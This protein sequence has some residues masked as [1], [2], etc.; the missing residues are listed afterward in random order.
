MNQL[1]QHEDLHIKKK[2]Y[3][4]TIVGS[5]VFM[6]IVML[7]CLVFIQNDKLLKQNET[8]ILIQAENQELKQQLEQLKKDI[9]NLQKQNAVLINKKSGKSAVIP[10]TAYL[11]FDDG[12]STNT[13]K[14]LDVLAEHNVKATFFI[15]GRDNQYYRMLYQRMINEGHVIAPHTYSHRYSEIY[16]SFES[17]VEDQTKLVN[18]ILDLGVQNPYIMR[19]PGGSGNTVAAQFGGAQLMDQI[20]KHYVEL[21]YK[22]FDWNVDSMDSSADLL[23]AEQIA[24]NV[25]VASKKLSDPIILMHDSPAKKTTPYALSQIITQLKQAGYKFDVLSVNVKPVVQKSIS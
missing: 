2:Y 18:L 15:V 13:E 25:I 16:S 8:I 6:A 4:I 19:F 7:F 17:F 21:G 1:K 5:F 3:K 10:Q 11:T 22:Y 24:N 12:P 14:I 9:D 23:T 20:L